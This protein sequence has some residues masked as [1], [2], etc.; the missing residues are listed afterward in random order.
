[1]SK[2]FVYLCITDSK[3]M[4]TGVTTDPTRRIH[5]H[6]HTKKCAKCLRGQRPVKLVWVAYTGA[7]SEALKLEYYIK[8][9]TRIEKIKHMFQWPHRLRVSVPTLGEYLGIANVK[10]FM[11]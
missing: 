9:L 8:S 3:K 2:W 6:N 7:R 11:D 4:Y 10:D 5:E 1:M